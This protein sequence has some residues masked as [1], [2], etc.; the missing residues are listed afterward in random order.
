M[1]I[2]LMDGY[3]R[4][5]GKAL[6]FTDGL[7]FVASQEHA[8]SVASL[9]ETLLKWPRT[10]VIAGSE[11]RVTTALRSGSDSAHERFPPVLVKQ[12]CL[13]HSHGKVPFTMT[14]IPVGHYQN[15]KVA[16]KSVSAFVPEPLPPVLRDQAVEI[17]ADRIDAAE[18]AL[19]RLVEAAQLISLPQ[20][21]IDAF[22][23]NE[24][25]AASAEGGNKATLTD[26]LAYELTKQPG[27]S[28]TD[29]VEDIM[30]YVAATQYGLDKLH[31]EEG[32][33]YFKW[34]LNEC[35]RI[36]LQGQRHA[37]QET[38]EFRQS[39]NWIGGQP[40]GRHTIYVPP[41]PEHVARLMDNLEYFLHNDTNLPPLLQAAT[42]H[43][44]FELIHPY[45]EGNGRI[46][47]MLITCVLNR[48][49]R[50]GGPILCL[51]EY[52]NENRA[53]YFFQF[54]ELQKYGNW[55]SWFLFFLKGVES[56]AN[57]AVNTLGQLQSR[58][59]QDRQKLL[60]EEGVT[61]A[62][63]RLLELLPE[64]LVVS[65]PAVRQLLRTT[66]PTAGKAIEILRHAGILFE[67]GKRTRNRAYC[68]RPYISEGLY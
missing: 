68:Y 40:P 9:I 5:H 49:E 56:V 16:G 48:C 12:N 62:A 59:H 50:R 1:Q 55:Y 31:G 2:S 43:A 25:L 19:V 3:A 54:G 46:G 26:V 38:G 21:I 66:K 13:Q 53:D 20:R 63:L 60:V 29:D 8:F 33:P 61:V 24:A 7:F 42:A 45:L 41:A 30:N 27:S 44:Q 52:F 28:S 67:V 58:V 65:M 35:H 6:H 64:N 11:R 17:L 34:L 14:L 18:A 32:R 47:R 57:D 37:D 23:I 36:L 39:Q 10:R 15:I 51:S 22:F 4:E